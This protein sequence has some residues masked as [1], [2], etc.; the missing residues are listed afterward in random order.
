MDSTYQIFIASSLRL[1][2]HRRAISQAINEVNN[3][4]AAKECN[5]RFSEFIYEKRPDILQKMEKYD[6]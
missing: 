6:A 3:S 4:Q 1:K 5:I 2:E